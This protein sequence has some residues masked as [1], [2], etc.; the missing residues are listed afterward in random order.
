MSNSRIEKD[1]YYL[2]IAKEVAARATCL[3][4]RYGAVI[5][6][7]DEII[8]TGYNGAPRGEP[9]CIDVGYCQREAIGAAKGERYELCKSIHAEQN[10]I[11]S[12]ARRDMMGGTIYITGIEK[13][14]SYADP[15]P[16]IMCRRFIVNAGIER[17]V[18]MVDGKPKEISLAPPAV[19]TPDKPAEEEPASKEPEEPPVEIATFGTLYLDGVPTFVPDSSEF[20]V[21][22][23]IPGGSTAT[24]SISIGDTVSGMELHWVRVGDN[25]IC[26][27][28]VLLRVSM[29]Q[30]FLAGLYG[31]AG[32][33]VTIDGKP[34]RLRVPI[35]GCF[36]EDDCEITK[37]VEMCHGD[38]SILHMLPGFWGM[39]VPNDRY[40]QSYRDSYPVRGFGTNDF[41]CLPDGS[42][43]GVGFRPVLE[44]VTIDN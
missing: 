25:Y 23:H 42:Y 19:S 17:C 44:P 6:K 30:L 38:S 10:A 16:C 40:T 39:R 31:G 13:D 2:N 36:R 43:P 28:V 37:A 14:G 35:N 18:G 32:T 29:K 24:P 41:S 21:L 4:R 9:N 34:Y 22:P 12:A 8:S 20:Q 5:V 27:R 1:L 15:T 3:R 7:N 26:D 11:I 33:P